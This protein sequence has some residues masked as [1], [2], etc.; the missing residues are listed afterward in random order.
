M[1]RL[2]RH[3][4]NAKLPIESARTPAAAWYMDQNYH[5]LDLGRVLHTSW[6]VVAHQQQLDRPGA[7]LA[8]CTSGQPWVVLRDAQ[9]D[10]KAFANVC[11]HNGTPVAE[12]RGVTDKLVCRY[13][14]WSYDLGGR[15]LKAPRIAGIA[16]FD[17]DDFALAPLPVKVF[18]PLILVI[19]NGK[20]C[21]FQADEVGQSLNQQRWEQLILR[22]HRRYELACNWKVFVDNYLDGGY[23][24]PSLHQDLASDLDFDSYRTSTFARSSLQTVVS[25]DESGERLAGEALY[26]WIYP[27]IMINRYGPMMD[28]NV[29]TP[30][31]PSRCLVT[32]DWYFEADCTDQFIEQSLLASDQVQREDIEVCEAVQRGM[33]SLHFRPGPY[34]PRVEMGKFEFH[35]LLAADYHR[36]D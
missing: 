18:G 35:R 19:L 28:I 12:G 34:A 8:G 30:L 2:G 32:F 3:D 4:F 24:V 17:R 13:H 23:H 25:D 27:N 21:D 6:Q 16:D 33:G 31:S 11:R 5:E 22:H 14:G 29:V 1:P 15:L 20:G 9:G 7:Y 10:L 36:H 26:V